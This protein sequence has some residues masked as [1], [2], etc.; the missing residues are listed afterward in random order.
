MCF[1]R[2]ILSI[3]T[4]C[5]V[6][7][8]VYSDP[9][10]IAHRG[11]SSVAP[12]N[13]IAAVKRALQVNPLPNYIE[14]DLHASKDG[15]LVVSH[16]DNTHRT[17]GVSKMIRDHSFA[18]LRKLDAGY[19]E[20]FQTQFKNEKLPRLEEVLDAVKDTHVGIMIECKQLLVEDR[21]IELLR[22]RNEL[23]KHVIAS[24]D[25]L[26][27]YRAKKIEPKV[28]TLYLTGD[29]T[30]TSIGRAKDVK[31]DIIGT[32]QKAHP[33]SAKLAQQ[34]GYQ[35]WVWT[36]DKKEDIQKWIDAG[37]EGIITN[38]PQRAVDLLK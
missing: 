15:V 23:D 22:K 1:L 12:E 3:M 14:I 10:I 16:D 7:N 37:V 4:M 5:V 17:T 35:V 21:V 9:L 25:E 32:N 31:A 19:V 30:P 27:C 8:S 26:T 34:Q 13:T 11:Y 33:A 28:R 6:V 24:F 2:M 20:K 38:V 36:V 29:I 18:D